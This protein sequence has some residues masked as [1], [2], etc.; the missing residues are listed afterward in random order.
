[1]FNIIE[2][3][4]SSQLPYI[5]IS[6]DQMSV[7]INGF[8]YDFH[9]IK[10]RIRAECFKCQV[11]AFNCVNFPCL[12]CERVDAKLGFFTLRDNHEEVAD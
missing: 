10:S 12:M 2:Q 8:L 3:S 4:D 7:S 11:F 9:F 5:S 6:P 1:M